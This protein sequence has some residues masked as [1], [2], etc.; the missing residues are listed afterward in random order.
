M[1]KTAQREKDKNTLNA[2]LAVQKSMLAKQTEAAKEISTPDVTSRY[3]ILLGRK[4]NRMSCYGVPPQTE[5][6]LT[7]QFA[8]GIPTPGHEGIFST[9][10]STHTH[11]G[12][13]EGHMYKQWKFR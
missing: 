12:K 11:R 1:S 3:C 4:Q 9:V 7:H 8:M 5:D 2:F 13:A 10:P 6:L